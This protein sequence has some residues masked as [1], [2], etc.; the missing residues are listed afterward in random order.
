MRS[1]AA[2]TRAVLRA[3]AAI[4]VEIEIRATMDRVW[5]LTQDPSLH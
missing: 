4:Y 1:R 3:R 2:S 5:E